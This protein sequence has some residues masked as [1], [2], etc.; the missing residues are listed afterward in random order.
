MTARALVCAFAICVVATPA[1]ADD[2]TD[3]KAAVDQKINA[4][5]SQLAAHQANESALRKEIDSVTSRIRTLE[6]NVGDVSL[7][8]ATLEK[9]LSLH[10]ERL[11]KLSKLFKLQSARLVVL[12]HQ[13]RIAVTRLDHRLVAIYMGGQPTVLE[14][15]FGATSIDDMLDKVDYMSRIAREDQSIARDVQ[16]SK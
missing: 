6:A 9:D 11:V 2:I 3:Q 8:L 13:Y 10:R 7:Q 4:L 15:V 12:R 1:L 14:F 5:S 16:H